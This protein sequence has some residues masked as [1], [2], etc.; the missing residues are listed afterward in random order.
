VIEAGVALLGATEALAADLGPAT[1]RPEGWIGTTAQ[2]TQGLGLALG[3][4]NLVILVLAWRGLR[5]GGNVMA[6]GGMLIVGITLL[7]LLV[8]FIG[9]LH[10]FHGME[11]VQSCGSCHVM[12]PYVRDLTDP[13]SEG[14]AAVHYK[15]RYIQENQCYTCHSDYGMFGTA[16]AKMAGVRHVY[17]HVTGAYTLPIKIAEPYPNVRCLGCHG[18]SQ[19]F[20]KSET[21]AGEVRPQ[22]VSGTVSCLDCHAPAHITEAR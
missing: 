6:V 18:E 13:K 3:L 7:P 16:A 14:L 15:N 20:L 9:Y 21:H 4:I 22:L 19:K 17:D 1:A 11:T 8:T 10:G 5:R 12:T 2:W